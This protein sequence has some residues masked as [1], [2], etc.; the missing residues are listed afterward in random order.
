[1]LEMRDPNPSVKMK[2]NTNAISNKYKITNEEERITTN[3]TL[4][5]RLYALNNRL[6]RYKRRQLQYQQNFD[7][8]TSHRSSLT[9]FVEIELKSAIHQQKKMSR[10]SELFET[11]KTFQPI[12]RLAPTI[13]RIFEHRWSHLQHYN[14][15]RNWKSFYQVFKLEKSW[16]WQTSKLLVVSINNHPPKYGR[17]FRH[18][19]ST[20]RIMSRMAYERSNNIGI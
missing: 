19:R 16:H 3:E 14:S 11:K 7:F 1:M 12:G 5:Q 6:S 4:K 2:N 20:T 13:Q 18:N 17:N 9:N 8:T 10:N 15:W